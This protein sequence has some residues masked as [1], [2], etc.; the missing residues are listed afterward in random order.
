MNNSMKT[1]RNPWKWVPTLYFAE[2]VPYAAVM[3]VS[4]LMYKRLGISNTDIALYTSWLNLPW[5]IKPFWSPFVDFLKTKRWWILAMQLI[6][7]ASLAGVA[8]VIP[9]PFFFQATLAL[10]WLLAFSSAT[11]DIAADGFYMIALDSNQ[12][13]FFVGIRSTFYRLAIVAC[14]GLLV[15]LA[16]ML[17]N[18]GYGLS[19]AWSVTFGCMSVI[20]IALFVYHFFV[21][22]RPEINRA[23]KQLDVKQVGREFVETFATF[24]RKKN[25]VVAI[26]FMLLYRFPEAQLT[27][28]VMP[29][30]VDPTDKGGL[31]LSTVEIGFVYGT[32][33]VIGL[34]L[35]G[36]VGGMAAS[37]GGLKKWLWPMALAITLPDIVFVVLSHVLPSSLIFINICV[38]IEQFGYGF[39]FAAYMLYMIYFS[40]GEHSTAHYAICTAF[41][42]LGLML[43]GMFAGWLQEKLGYEM[44]FC[45]VMGCC[46]LTLFVT[47]LIKIDPDFGK[48]KA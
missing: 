15:M 11:H 31:A 48:K 24:F 23:K 8:L 34:V 12:Q 47:S 45:W 39:G 21:L 19:F 35:G 3:I 42:T 41:M 37:V 36:I 28:I 26:A 4:I 17:E 22:P 14:Q 40:E 32:I 9:V 29:F 33:G 18:M 6:V 44:F 10:F 38:F 1:L 27:K 2:A 7:G 5:M 16:G 20:F 25:V 46:L 13:S 30:L 43:P